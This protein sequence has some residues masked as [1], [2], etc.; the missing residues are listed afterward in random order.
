M[1]WLGLLVG[2]VGLLVAL[3][4]IDGIRDFFA[5]LYE[6]KWPFAALFG[7]AAIAAVV[8]L[9]RAGRGDAHVIRSNDD[10]V[11]ELRSTVDGATDWLFCV[12]SRGRDH[13]Y[14]QAIEDRVNQ[15]ADLVYTRVLCGEP[16]HAVMKNHLLKLPSNAQRVRVALLS[17]DACQEPEQSICASQERAVIVVPAVGKFDRYDSGI[18]VSRKQ[19]VFAVKRYIEDL[20]GAATPLKTRAELEA[21]KPTRTQPVEATGA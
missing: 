12:G 4:V 20:Y 21:L 14:L 9:L 11:R 5:S 13:E 6:A 3:V 15:H 1:K 7:V 19:D 2:V 16:H 18:V 17:A 8:I 10:L